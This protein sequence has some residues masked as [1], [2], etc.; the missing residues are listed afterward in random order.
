MNLG[1]CN[2]ALDCFD[3]SIVLQLDRSEFRIKKGAALAKQ[4]RYYEALAHFE[5]ALEVDPLN[6]DAGVSR[7]E[8]LQRMSRYAEAIKDID[9]EIRCY[10]E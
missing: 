8:A 7:G 4:H 6:A 5:W 10:T 9:Q 1:D 2:A 3:R